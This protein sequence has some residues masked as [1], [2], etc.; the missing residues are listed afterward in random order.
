MQGALN[1]RVAELEMELEGCRND[2]GL[3]REELKATTQR[4]LEAL[5]RVEETRL[6]GEVLLAQMES[7]K[8]LEHSLKMSQLRLSQ[9]EAMITEAELRRCELS[10]AHETFQQ[11]TVRAECAWE[12]ERIGMVE[13]HANRIREE[14]TKW[15]KEVL[16]LQEAI[17]GWKKENCRQKGEMEA[18]REANDLAGRQRQQHGKQGGMVKLQRLYKAQERSSNQA[19]VRCWRLRAVYRA[20]GVERGELQVGMAALR[21]TVDG[22]GEQ[23]Q[24]KRRH[25]RQLMVRFT[26]TPPRT[27]T[28]TFNPNPTGLGP[29]LESPVEVREGWDEEAHRHLGVPRA[30]RALLSPVP[31]TESGSPT[32]GRSAEPPFDRVSLRVGAARSRTPGRESLDQNEAEGGH[33]KPG[34][35]P[36]GARSD[37]NRRKTTRARAPRGPHEPRPA[38]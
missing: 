1:I 36:R 34:L 25:L 11:E 10:Q 37:Q 24:G 2:L 12:R 30:R 15:G 5:Q 16:G 9:E 33:D 14:T 26:P 22:L 7:A 4:E 19:A 17:T 27:V 8:A 32:G 29:R 3:T 28:R 35:S 18:W 6:E 21:D 38:E 23:L 31:E 20:F 13:H